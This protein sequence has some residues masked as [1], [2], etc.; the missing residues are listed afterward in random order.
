MLFRLE[1]KTGADFVRTA[2]A[3]RPNVIPPKE[4][5]KLVKLIDQSSV[6]NLFVPESAKDYD[7]IDI[8]ASA[9]AVSKG[10]LVGSGVIRLLEQDE[11][12]LRKRIQTLQNQSENRFVLGVGTG[13]EGANPRKTIETMLLRLKKI[14]K[15]FENQAVAEFP[16]TYIATLRIGIAKNVAGHSDGILLNFC[17]PEYAKRLIE[18]YKKSFA[19]NTDF[20]CYLK[21]FYS[22]NDRIAEDL[23]VK[24][25]ENYSM[26]PHYSAMFEI[27]GIASEIDLA[28]KAISKG[29]PLPRS[30]LLGIS[31][32]NPSPAELSEYIT[33]FRK[34]GVTLPC[35]YPYFSEDDDFEFRTSIFR[36]IIS[37]SS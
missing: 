9:L 34:A 32:A 6:T 20:G 35:V 17:S 4:I 26:I 5:V 8:C 29:D 13:S 19:G 18:S 31:L 37:A 11:K 2:I 12:L 24:E 28:R 10:I 27:D 16:S 23:L 21:V 25:F 1:S 15:D 7:S 36:S 33:R 22:K 30:P 3:L 14:R